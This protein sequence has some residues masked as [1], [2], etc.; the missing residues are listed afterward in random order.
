MEYKDINQFTGKKLWL[1]NRGKIS[2]DY[3]LTDNV[4]SYGLMYDDNS[5]IAK[6]H[7]E[8][9]DD[10]ILVL[11]STIGNLAIKTPEGKVIGYYET[12]NKVGLKLNNG[13]KANF[14]VTSLFSSEYHWL[15]ENNHELIRI[16]GNDSSQIVI[17]FI[18]LASEILYLNVLILAGV[19]TIF[20]HNEVY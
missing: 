3:D 7:L 9:K 13:F 20:N 17:T 12:S 5:F 10:I 16:S 14:N 4:N 15:D 6:T 8:T 19:K 1:I 18:R 2:S 11:N